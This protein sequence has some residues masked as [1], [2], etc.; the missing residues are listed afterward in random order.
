[1]TKKRVLV[2]E[3]LSTVSGGQKMTL[4]VIDMLSDQYEFCCLIPTEGMLSAELKKRNIPYVIMGDQSL[5]TG[6]KGKQ[7]IFRYGWMSAKNIWKSIKVI[8]NYKP[9]LLYCPG[10]AALPWSAICGSIIGKPV[11]WHLHHIFLD[12]TTKKLLNFCGTWKCV[13]KIIAVSNCVG[14]QI[15]VETAKKKV[16]VIYNPVDFIKYAN[17]NSALIK[18]EIENFL[19]YEFNE[20]QLV[21]GHIALIQRSKRQDF[22]LDVIAGLKNMGQ[23]PIGVFAGE[24]REP[25]FLEELKQKSKRIGVSERVL[26]LGRRNDIPAVLKMLDVLIIPSSFEGFPLAGLEAASAGVPVAA[27]NVAGAEEFIRVSGDG[28]CFIEDDVND[29]LKATFLC[30]KNKEQLT[31]SGM[32]F[33]QNCSIGLYCNSIKR[34]FNMLVFAE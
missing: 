21:V 11:I 24:V 14:E 26:F 28:K 23:N 13:K 33:A 12:G 30:V 16:E 5:P 2:W 15:S 8:R 31:K 18:S 32:V 19:G 25:E 22:V 27:C 34:V 29:A 1:M 3:T 6:V 10:P 4:T 9:N 17:G 7:I 20:K